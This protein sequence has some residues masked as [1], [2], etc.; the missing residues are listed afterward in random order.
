MLQNIQ[1]L[2]RRQRIMVFALIM[3]GGLLALAGITVLL[4]FNG[5]NSQSATQSVALSENVTVREFAALPDDDA[6][7]AALVVGADGTVYSGSY[8]TGALWA[9]D[10]EGQASEIPGTREAIGAVAGLAVAPDGSILIVDQN[11]ADPRTGGGDLKRLSPDKT[12]VTT[13]A[14]IPAGFIAPDDVTVDAAGFVYVSDRGRDEV[15]LFDANGENGIMWWQSPA[16]EGKEEYA[17]TGL[18]YDASTDTIL[19]TD[20]LLDTLYRV[21]LDGATTDIIYAHDD[22]PDAPGFDGLTVMPDGT[23]YVAA[24]AQSGIV[25]IEGDSLTYIAGLFRGGSDVDYSPQANALYVTNFDSQPLVVPG[26]SPRLPFTI[27]VVSFQ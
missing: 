4:I 2:P 23:I 9:I 19:I 1:R 3:I 16:V 7:P 5:L 6:Y 24:L 12:T 26:R 11:D 10:A 15:W 17:P 20:G 14:T 8:V 21:S 18:A 13:F 25:R 27:D 22:R